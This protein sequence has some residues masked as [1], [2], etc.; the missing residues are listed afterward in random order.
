M[1]QT[2][3]VKEQGG[4]VDIIVR[5]QIPSVPVYIRVG[6]IPHFNQYVGNLTI[7]WVRITQTVLYSIISVPLSEEALVCMSDNQSVHGGIM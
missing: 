2:G 1:F 5:F 3:H 6:G 7:Q 4:T